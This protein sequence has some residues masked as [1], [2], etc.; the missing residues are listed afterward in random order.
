MGMQNLAKRLRKDDSDFQTLVNHVDNWVDS[1]VLHR[2]NIKHG[3]T[4][5]F[6]VLRDRN[7]IIVANEYLSF[8]SDK[9]YNPVNFKK[10]D[11]IVISPKDCWLEYKDVLKRLVELIEPDD[12]ILY[13]ASMMS[14]VLIDDIYHLFGDEVTQIDVG[15][16]FDPYCGIKSRSYHHKLKV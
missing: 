5:F 11:H 8:I 6:D 14:E 3:L 2:A 10:Y 13:A 7:I 4:A 1:D 12:V 16:A 15:S 9:I